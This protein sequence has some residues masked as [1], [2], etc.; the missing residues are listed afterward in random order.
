MQNKNKLFSL[1][2][3]AAFLAIIVVMAFTPIG[4]LKVARRCFPFRRSSRR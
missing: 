1:T 3:T 2:L 4:Y